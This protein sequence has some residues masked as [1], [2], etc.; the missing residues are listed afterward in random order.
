MSNVI[1]LRDYNNNLIMIDTSIVMSAVVSNDNYYSYK[2][3]PN[4]GSLWEALKGPELVE[5]WKLELSGGGESMKIR[6]NTS[7][8][9]SEAYLKIV[10]SK[11]R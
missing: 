2:N 11:S 10:Q 4:P 6:F 9:V 8:E 7:E 3:G 5:A 1:Q